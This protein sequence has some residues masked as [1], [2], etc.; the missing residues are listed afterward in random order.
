MGRVLV[1]EADLTTLADAIREKGGT[2]AALT[3]PSGFN[4]AINQISGGG[5]N[6]IP[7]KVYIT[8]T[9]DLVVTLCYEQSV[10]NGV[11]IDW[12]DDSETNTVS[13]LTAQ[14]T[15]TYAEAGEYII[16]I[17]A[18]DGATWKAGNDSKTLFNATINGNKSGT[19]SY[20]TSIEFGESCIGIN[21][22]QNCNELTSITFGKAA[23]FFGNECFNGCTKLEAVYISNLLLWC[24]CSFPTA[25]SNPLSKAHDLYL[26]DTKIISLTLPDAINTRSFKYAFAGASITSVVIPN[27][28]T[29][30]SEG[31]FYNCSDLQ[32]VT[33]GNINLIGD[34]AFS[35]C[36]NLTSFTC[37]TLNTIGNSS[38]S[39][40]YSLQSFTCEG[41][42]DSI[43][44]LAFGYD[45]NL[46][47]NSFHSVKRIGTL[48]FLLC[49][50]S[51]SKVPNTIKYMGPGAFLGTTWTNLPNHTLEIE[52][53]MISSA[54]F[55][56]AKGFY[57]IV[58]YAA[59]NSNSD[60]SCR[61]IYAKE[62]IGNI[63]YEYPF[64][65]TGTELQQITVHGVEDRPIGWDVDF[66]KH[67]DEVSF[68]VDYITS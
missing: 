33:C 1:N 63:T 66:D 51:A 56:D 2:S 3:W 28:I 40:C 11:I 29:E 62:T 6:I 46:I 54:A 18:E 31:A 19:T 16:T 4:T 14:P 57:Q 55:S 8:L 64:G 12:G 52:S 67:T 24:L 65:G 26:N 7:T 68:F 17:S 22:I 27:S 13:N 36:G 58:L 61:A 35:N 59:P 49:K 47:I 25:N 9:S 42:L 50:I 32:S 41:N 5:N 30:I 48:A 10:A 34:R 39:D 53:A 43:G 20:V 37:G 60:K 38:F 45:N 44:D 23:I 15:H 21:S